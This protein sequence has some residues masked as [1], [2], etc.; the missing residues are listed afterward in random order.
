MKVA[1]TGATGF[2]GRAI[3]REA[4]GRGF[5]VVAPYRSSPPSGEDLLRPSGIRW[6]AWDAWERGDE[7]FDVVVHSAALRHRHGVA[8]EE[9]ER[10][11][12]DLTDR[13]VERARRAKVNRFV[14]V[15]SIATYGWPSNLPIDESFPPNPVGRYGASKVETERRVRA[16]GLPLTI[17]QPSITYGPG[18]TNGMIDKMMRMI[19]KSAFV[20][21]GL[22][23]T[24]V[25]LAYIDDVGRLT[26]DAALSARTLGDRFICTYKDPIRVGDLVRKIAR[27]V[28]GRVAPFGPPTAL[29]RLAGGGL[30]ALDRFG[31]FR[32]KEPPLTREKLATISVDRAYRIDHLRDLLGTEPRVG[33]DEG[34]ALTARAMGL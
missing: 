31:L 19:A 14:Y 22:G 1:V 20:I 27:I 5:E 8:A 25:Q 34:L 12:I 26:V 13:V 4:A 3:A 16:S 6:V 7:R 32:G 33:Y 29:L 9:Y 17:V 21:P 18:D 28:G 10:V 23:R 15:S 24:R 2:I 30:E 11:N